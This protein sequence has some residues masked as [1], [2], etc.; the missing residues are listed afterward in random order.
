MENKN[1]IYFGK[2][3]KV[4]LLEQIMRIWFGLLRKDVSEINNLNK[5]K[6]EL[7]EFYNIENIDY[8]DY[9]KNLQEFSV[10]DIAFF[11]EIENSR[12][13]IYKYQEQTGDSKF[14]YYLNL[15]KFLV[16]KT[17]EF[18]FG[19]NKLIIYILKKEDPYYIIFNS[20]IYV[21]HNYKIMKDNYNQN[22]NICYKNF[23][24]DNI[25]F[26]N[27][28]F[29]EIKKYGFNISLKDGIS[30][31]KKYYNSSTVVLLLPELMEK[32]Y[33]TISEWVSILIHEM[34]HVFSYL[35]CDLNLL[36][37]RVNENFADKFV[38]LYG[39]SSEFINSKRKELG[40][41][42]YLYYNGKI[43]KIKKDNEIKFP[44]CIDK[45]HIIRE[46]IFNITDHAPT[47]TRC[48]YL[49]NQL[50]LELKNK[51]LSYNK[52]LEI[53]RDVK[54]VKN[55]IKRY[56]NVPFNIMKKKDL[57]YKLF[58]KI[59]HEKIIKSAYIDNLDKVECFI[60]KINKLD[61]RLFKN[62]FVNLF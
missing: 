51:Y 46:T 48:L 21:N 26:E 55:A 3:K 16:E 5:Y 61:R 57:K 9:K 22:I 20:E 1:C 47:Y 49:L 33:F 23:N 50:K 44:V 30:F 59:E 25:M 17:L 53:N 28:T 43:K 14:C 4:K 18:A 10:L 29:E 35:L 13:C 39:Y 24:K 31:N 62:I 38:S 54:K 32:C 11:K 27:K 60:E 56:K 40:M 41:K 8:I 34:G 15:C 58:L 12:N 42:L 19:I 52:R 45:N 6:Q 37:D 2:I 36:S 7:Q